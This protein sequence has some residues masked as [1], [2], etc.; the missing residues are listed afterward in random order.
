MGNVPLMPQGD[1]LESHQAVCPDNTGNATN[2]LRNDRIPLVRH[3]ARSFLSFC[4]TF[5]CL[6][7]FSS[8]PVSY[9]ER[10]FVERRSDQRECAEILGVNVALNDLRG[11]RR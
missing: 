9:C 3:R 8:L 4:K 10:K 6:S 7:H 2:P 5:L 11:N 1:I